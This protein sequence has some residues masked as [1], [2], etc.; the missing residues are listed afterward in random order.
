MSPSRQLD[1]GTD[2]LLASVSDGVGTVILNRPD[3][4]NAMSEAM[5]TALG[6]ALAALDEDGDVGAVVITGAGSAFCAGGDVIGFNEQGGEGGTSS[7]VDPARVTRQQKD[8]RATVGR[9]HSMS[10]PV[11][12]ALPGAAAGAGVGIALAA[13]LR[14]G[15]PRTLLAT[16]F[17]AVGL[18]GD[19]GSAWLLNRLVGPAKARELLFLGDRVNSEECLRLGL[20]NWLV[21]EDELAD[22]AAEVASALAKG[23]RLA[24]RYM[25]RNL[26]LADNVD[27]ET[28]MDAEVA[29][30]ME[31]GVT[32]DH[33]GA[34]AAFA[35]KRKPVFGSKPA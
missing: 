26:I 4:R 1:T 7:E 2:D 19:Y 33:R 10:K 30:H 3:R 15:C 23:P 20:V 27:L 8:Q 25:K 32:E 34:I 11:I 29:L 31:C 18:S 17:S 21:A 13:D 28:S 35:E 5:V 6:T 22:K 16:A 14:V 12:A 9:I 24:L